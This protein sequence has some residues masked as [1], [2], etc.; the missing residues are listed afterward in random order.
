MGATNE[1]WGVHIH[2]RNLPLGYCVVDGSSGQDTN[3]ELCKPN[4]P[5]TKPCWDLQLESLL[6]LSHAFS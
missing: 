2:L 4:T 5:S 1:G 6:I 3:P